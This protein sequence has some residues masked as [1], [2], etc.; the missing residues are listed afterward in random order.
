MPGIH[1]LIS[2]HSLGEEAINSARSLFKKKLKDMLHYPWYETKLLFEDENIMVGFS[3][4][5]RY[6]IKVFE[7]DSV[8]IVIEGTIYS[9]SMKEVGEL[10]SEPFDTQYLKRFLLSADGEFIIVKYD[11][12]SSVCLVFND[13]FGRLP[14]YYNISSNRI[15]ASREMKFL[16]PFLFKI[17]LDKV[18][19]AEYLLFR[20]PL[21][22]RTLVKDVYRLQPATLIR[23]NIQNNRILTESIL[24]WNL[25]SKLREKP[26]VRDLELLESAFLS[27]LKNRSKTFSKAVNALSLSGGLDSRTVLA[28]LVKIGTVPLAFTLLSGAYN[29]GEVSIAKKVSEKMKVKHETF[30]LKDDVEEQEM[31]RLTYLK[32][33]V[34]SARL[35][36]SLKFHEFM[37]EKL[38]NNLVVYTGTGG[39]QILPSL[40]FNPRVTCLKD[41]ILHIITQDHIFNLKEISLLLNIDEKFLLRHLE[42]HIS[43]YPEK[44]LEGKCKHFKIFEGVF[45]WNFEGE[46]TARFYY[47]DTVPFYYIPF[48]KRAMEVPEK[49]KKHLGLYKSF[50]NQLDPRCNQ[51]TYY[52]WGIPL[53]IPNWML[54]MFSHGNPFSTLRRVRNKKSFETKKETEKLKRIVRHLLKSKKVEKYFDVDQFKKMLDKGTSEKKLYVLITLLLYIGMIDG[55]LS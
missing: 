48:F 23:G 16:V 22:K 9:H 6:P 43:S 17:N 33:G 42:R 18:S 41:L 32:D 24:S 50:L 37:M 49:F 5:Q 54:K 11:K 27:S 38:G 40:Q 21:G 45:K 2:T 7:T 47:W 51:I 13:A 46:D 39:D 35:S 14:F 31:S 52:N 36:Y 1:C 20:Y 3:G 19:L 55:Q 29:K 44:T 12:Q 53:S 30:P 4:H 15:L 25:D 10:L 28:G 26:S 34:L 8:L